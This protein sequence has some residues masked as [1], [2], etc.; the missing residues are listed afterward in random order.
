MPIENL[1]LRAEKVAGQIG[2]CTFIKSVT[3]VEEQSMLGGGS[4]PDQRI[5][6]WCVSIEPQDVT[7]AQITGKLR[8]ATPAVM[9][10]VFKDRLLLDMRTIDP[11][12]DLTL[13][14]IFEGL[15]I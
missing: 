2:A 11:S 12:Q 8:A 1:K 9:G 15:E 10:R 6:T 13:V 4:L 3:A 7:L 14:E 5:G